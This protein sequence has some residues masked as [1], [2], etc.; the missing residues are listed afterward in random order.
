M[1]QSQ[2]ILATILTYAGALPF[3]ACIALRLLEFE[4]IDTMAIIT[5]YGAVILSFL[6]GIHWSVYLFCADTCP[7]NLFIRSSIIAL[8]AWVSLLVKNNDLTFVIQ[9]ICF[10]Y[11]LLLDYKLKNL[12]ILEHWFYHLRRNVTCVVTSSLLSLIL[13]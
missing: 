1:R 4:T 7:K 11:L 6:C 8:L 2:I 12:E 9:I 10:L 3:I 13:I 5:T